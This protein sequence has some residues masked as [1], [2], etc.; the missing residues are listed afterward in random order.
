MAVVFL[1]LSPI[2]YHGTVV[3]WYIFTAYGYGFIYIFGRSPRVRVQ[4]DYNLRS[5]NKSNFIRTELLSAEACTPSRLLSAWALNPALVVFLAFSQYDLY[6]G[7]L[8][9]LF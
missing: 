8:R 2:L 7:M 6:A 3:Y 9:R 1:T 4:L 5:L